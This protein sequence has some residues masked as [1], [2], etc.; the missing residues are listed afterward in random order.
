M[1]YTD[2]EKVKVTLCSNTVIT[3]RK[4]SS[5]RSSGR[6]HITILIMLPQLLWQC[7]TETNLI[8]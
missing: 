3:V 4:S 5:A 7:Q 1:N 8:P 2:G 6:Q